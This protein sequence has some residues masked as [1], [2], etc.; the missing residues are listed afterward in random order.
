MFNWWKKRQEARNAPIF[1]GIRL[2]QN[3]YLGYTTIQYSN[4]SE[5]IISTCNVHFFVNKENHSKRYFKYDPDNIDFYNH[6]WILTV[7]ELWRINE[8]Y[9]HGP[10]REFPSKWLKEYML[11]EYDAIWSDDKKLWIDN[12]ENKIE[13]KKDNII[14]VKFE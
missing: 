6:S 12:L 7:A 4:S 8:K 14:K 10:I 3:H 1:L 9:L 2:D 11:E 13:Y 5:K